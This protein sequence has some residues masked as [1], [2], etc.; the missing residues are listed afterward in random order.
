MKIA[1][2][3]ATGYI[4]ERLIHLAN[5]YGFSVVALSRSRPLFFVTE[6]IHYDLNSQMPVVLPNNVDVVFHLAASTSSANYL[7]S[8]AE[9]LAA[10]LILN[11]SKVVGAKFIYV[12]SQTARFD[13]PTLYGRTKWAIENLVLKSQ[14]IVIRPGQVYGGKDSGLFGLLVTVV[15]YLPILPAF[16]PE[17]QLQPVHVDDLSLAL[18]CAADQSGSSQQVYCIAQPDG[19]G[20]TRF[21]KSIASNRLNVR[22]LFIP[23]PIG[24]INA[25][26]FLIGER[27]GQRFGV[28]RL[29]SLFDLPLMSSADSLRLLKLS[30]RPLDQGMHKE[31]ALEDCI[32][33]EARVLFHYIQKEPP[34]QRQILRYVGCIQEC[35]GGVPMALPHFVKRYPVLLALLDAPDFLASTVGTEFGWR[36]D[37]AS[38]LSEATT[39]GAVR[40]MNAGRPGGLVRYVATLVYVLGM[41]AFWRL[42]RVIAMPLFLRESIN[43]NF[44]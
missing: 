30:L 11:S 36:L 40:L 42:V 5:S 2:T 1:V 19:L 12:S 34:N 41:E 23:I 37:A 32:R 25:V 9:L 44:Q 22:R 7:G 17:P 3:G 26:I 35:R 43:R 18:L 38:L 8:D 6:W 20:F 39:E 10:Q 28:T 4:G 21:L 31:V 14:G 27:I 29:K 15:S 24:F 16:I 13:A 33:E